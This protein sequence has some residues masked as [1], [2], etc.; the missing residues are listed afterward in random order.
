MFPIQ[1]AELIEA[2]GPVEALC[3]VRANEIREEKL[4]EE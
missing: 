2:L 4:T 3:K 1:K